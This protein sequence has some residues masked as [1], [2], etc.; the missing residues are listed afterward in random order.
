[1]KITLDRMSR[2]LNVSLHKT[3]EIRKELG[4]EKGSD[5][6]DS[7][8]PEYRQQLA[9]M[10]G[11]MIKGRN[12]HYPGFYEKALKII[13]EQGYIRPRQL[14]NTFES[15]STTPPLS[16]FETMENP[17]YDETIEQVVTVRKHY[18]EVQIVKKVKVFKLWNELKAKWKE[19]N[20][21]NGMNKNGC[22]GHVGRNV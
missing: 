19:E 14:A 9:K 17:L 6:D 12:P 13:E 11:E 16:F 21:T 4:Y 2:M 1:M 22:I 3:I 18:K 15:Y 5:Y 20:R 10:R 7:Q 8:I